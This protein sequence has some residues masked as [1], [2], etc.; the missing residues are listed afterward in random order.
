MSS[1][2][3]IQLSEYD[4]LIGS[5]V[6][7]S[8]VPVPGQILLD[9]KDGSGVVVARSACYLSENHDDLKLPGHRLSK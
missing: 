2:P 9:A 8:F 7:Q 1:G 3:H 4:C 6:H 5:D